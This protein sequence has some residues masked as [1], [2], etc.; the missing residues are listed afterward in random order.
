MPKDCLSNDKQTESNTMNT[1][2][3][4]AGLG[5]FTTG[6]EQAGATPVFA[7]NHWQIAIDWHEANHP[8]VEHVC[9]ELGEMDKTRIPDI[10]LL[11]ASP[12]CQGFSPNGRPGRVT[13][14]KTR[15][16]ADRNTSWAVVSACEI[17]RP[18]LLLVENVEEMA[19]WCLFPSWLDALQRLGYFV[20][21]HRFNARDFGLPQDRDRILVTGSLRSPIELVAP[22]ASALCIADV[23][24]AEPET[25]WVP[26]DSKT[27]QSKSGVMRDRM[28]AAQDQGGR[29]CFW[30]NVD[31]ARGRP[32]DDVFPTVTTKTIGQAYLLD[33]DR[34]RM[35]SP[36]ELARS[37]GF[38]DDYL[39]PK[40][41]TLAGKLIGNAIPVPMARSATEQILAAA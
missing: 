38:P 36:R 12:A 27:R 37:Q 22:G 30:A 5:G 21:V 10:G 26:I 14:A 4:F 2:D 41:R 34:C 15:H 40:N 23:L 9:Q 19:D 29:S 6:A 13:T 1:A 24:D 32:L 39:L 33:G 16:Q 31:S 17:K 28:R 8:N 35:L 11:V 7:A 25:A 3:F 20:R 18:E